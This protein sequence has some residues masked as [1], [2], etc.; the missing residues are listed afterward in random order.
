MKSK[1]ETNINNPYDYDLASFDNLAGGQK[2]VWKHIIRNLSQ[3]HVES[4]DPQLDGEVMGELA[5]ELKKNFERIDPIKIDSGNY[6][7]LPD[8]FNAVKEHA[9]RWQRLANSTIDHRMRC[10]RRMARHPIFPIDFFNLNHEQ[11][12]AYMQCRE[13]YEHAQHFALKNDL[14]SIHTFLRAFGIKPSDWFYRLP[15]E[16]KHRERIL[17][18]PET[19]HKMINFKY[20]EDAYENALYHYVHAHNFW[21]GWRVPSEPYLM[22]VDNIDFDTGSII[23]TERKK[24]NATRQIFPELSIMTGKTRKSFKNWLKWRDKVETSQSGNAL[25]LQ[26]SGKPFTLRH[27]G[28][29]IS[30][31]GKQ[32]WPAFRPYDSRHWCAVGRLIKTKIETGSFEPFTVQK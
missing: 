29:K 32:V 6:E 31:T 8:L 7:S 30:E 26:P 4:I 23:I 22:T 12:I 16:Q 25:Y 17:P 13:D 14:R 11:F 1:Q 15:P 10:A 20:S 2:E 5:Y 28:H 24:H 21:I 18:L 27:F 9:K 19:V 3:N